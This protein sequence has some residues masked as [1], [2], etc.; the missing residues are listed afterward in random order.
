MTDWQHT[1][2]VVGL[3]AG[4]LAIVREYLAIRRLRA[5]HWREYLT[6]RRLRALH[7]QQPAQATDRERAARRLSRTAR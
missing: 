4:G 6:I 2:L 5:L 3:L 7:Q 1:L